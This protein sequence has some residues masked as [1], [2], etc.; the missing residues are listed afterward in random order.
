[1]IELKPSVFVTAAAAYFFAH[2]ASPMLALELTVPSQ[3]TL[4]LFHVLD[5]APHCEVPRAALVRLALPV[6]LAQLITRTVLL[7]AHLAAAV[8]LLY[9]GKVS[10]GC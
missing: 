9:S 7:A 4:P 1:M 3:R 6:L 5:Q 8:Q 2:G 10:H